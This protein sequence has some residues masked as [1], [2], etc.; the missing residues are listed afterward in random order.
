MAGRQHSNLFKAL[1][2]SENCPTPGIHRE[3][4]KY[5]RRWSKALAISRRFG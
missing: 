1:I 4:G 5:V 2:F 3:P